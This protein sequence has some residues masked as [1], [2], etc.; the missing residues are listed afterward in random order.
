MVRNDRWKLIWYPKILEFQLFD[1]QTDPL[2]L[3]NLAQD[4]K[5]SEK[6]TEMKSLMAAQQKLF[7]DDKAP[8]PK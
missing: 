8:S 6:L 1:L 7:G 4:S 2:E 3:Q 5:W